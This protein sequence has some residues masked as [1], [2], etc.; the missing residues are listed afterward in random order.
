M[1]LWPRHIRLAIKMLYTRS[2]ND[3][4]TPPKQRPPLKHGIEALVSIAVWSAMGIGL[5]L[6]YIL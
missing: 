5:A 6:L 1:R 2:K 3:Y 4:P